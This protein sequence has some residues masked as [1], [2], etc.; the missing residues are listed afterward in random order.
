M[1]TVPRSGEGGGGEVHH[2]K[3]NCELNW[4]EDG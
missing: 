2:L 1:T 4:A 3:T